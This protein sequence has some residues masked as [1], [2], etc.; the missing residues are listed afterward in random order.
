[1]KTLALALTAMLLLVGCGGGGSAMCE[2]PGERGSCAGELYG[3][4]RLVETCGRTTSEALCA[5]AMATD[6]T[7]TESHLHFDGMN[8][9]NNGSQNGTQTATFPLACV[10]WT[11]DECDA[12]TDTT[13]NVS[14]TCAASG[15]SCTC[16]IHVSGT[17]SA[18][19]TYTVNGGFL[20]VMFEDKSQSD[21]VYCV[22]KNTLLIDGGE[23]SP[24]LYFKYVRE[25]DLP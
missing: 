5:T 2:D 14:T 8:Y 15:D 22:D 4:W 17:F 21:F 13:D 6:D 23:R 7:T 20:R 18:S 12:Y 19:G 1:M 3:T 11:A 24:Y 25:S 9:R 10:E 16:T